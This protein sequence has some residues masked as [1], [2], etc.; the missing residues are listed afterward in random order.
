[1]VIPWNETGKYGGHI[2][3]DEYTSNYDH[4]LRHILNI[5]LLYHDAS[6]EM[7]YGSGIGTP[8]VTKPFVFKSM[9]PNKDFTEWKIKLR[10]GFRKELRSSVRVFSN[11]SIFN[12]RS[13]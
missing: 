6:E 4:Y 11:S 12:K 2:I 9:T 7:G 10:V 5:G 8:A 1:M 13:L 3:W